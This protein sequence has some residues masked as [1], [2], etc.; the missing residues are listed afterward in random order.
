[1]R[2]LRSKWIMIAVLSCLIVSGMFSA[3]PAEASP[4]GDGVTFKGR[5]FGDPEKIATPITKAGISG[6]VVGEEDGKP[7]FYTS[8]NAEVA[9]F[10]IV[11]IRSNTLLR[12]FPMPGVQQA[13]AHAVAPDGTVYIGGIRTSGQ[14][15][16]ILWK[17]SPATKQI[18]ELGEPIPGEKSIWSLTVD[19]KGNVYGGTFQ[20]GRVFKYDPVA[21]T[22]T[23]YGT[24]VPGQEYVRSIAYHDGYIYAGIGTVGDVVKLGV[25]EATAGYKQSIGAEV[26]GLLGVSA[27]QVPFAYD[28][29][30]VGD[31]L[32]VKF[33][34]DLYKLLFYD[35]K[36]GAWLPHVVGKDTENG[37][38]GVG[39]FNFAQLAA[40]DNKV[41]IPANGHLTELDLTT[42]QATPLIRYGTSLRGA[43]WVSFDDLP[44]YPGQ[45]LVS[46][47]GN[48]EIAIFNVDA[49]TVYSMPSALIGAPNPIHNIEVG[50]DGSLYMSAYPAGLGA[51][52]DP[53]TAS[54]KNL[55][56]EQAEGMVAYG[57]DMYMGIY[58]G[59]HVYK[60]DTTQSTPVATRVF[61]IGE[62]QD[63]PY[64]M[65]T[66]GDK[67]MIGTIPGYGELG[68]ALTIFDPSTG[69]HKVY[70]N[71]VQNQ[72]IV[73]LAYKDGYIY[74]STT[75]HGGL[76]TSATERSA[77]LFVWDVANERKV[78]EFALDI[79]GIGQSP[80]IS[81]LTVGPD[82]N[83][84]GGV[85]G[86]LFKMDPV[87]HEILNYKN[88][89]PDITNYGMWRPYHPY[90]GK[91]GLLYI[92][93]ADR[94]TVIDPRTLEFVR[95]FPE[96]LEVKFMA[97]AEDAS[98][99]E[100][101]YF[102][103]ATDMG[104]LQRISVTDAQYER[105]GRLK[106]NGPD[107]VRLNETIEVALELEQAN[108]LYG[109]KAE[110]AIDP[111]VWTIE[112]VTAS[113]DWQS[114]GYMTWSADGGDVTIVGT[115]LGDNG[116]SLDGP[117]A[118]IRL[119][120]KSYRD[121]AR[122]ILLGES[123]TIRIDGD[124][125]GV[126]HRLGSDFVWPVTIQT[127]K[128][129]VNRDGVVTTDDLISLAGRIGAAIDDSN[130]HMDLN[131]DGEIDIADL[132]L[133]GSAV[134][135]LR[136]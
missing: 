75:I 53:R 63:R 103:D 86:I 73:G 97:L 109:F 34:G 66:M 44:G 123:E 12:S 133:V 47:K 118:K 14:T 110:L 22:F 13:W 6:A 129:D 114:N 70:R 48:G 121:K 101:I 108:A 135:E 2:K 42:F 4:G 21:G 45:S 98:G 82:G 3:A 7:V 52:Y 31:L 72:S 93:L 10:Q 57:T 59:G 88:I 65:K 100:Q 25:T 104:S 79:P 136:R 71:I 62:S 40:R 120:A 67:I 83:I 55:I 106:L 56:L 1:M 30:V 61:T 33:Q 117:L 18:V 77:K 5:V 122:L 51:V 54:L 125:T 134:F 128:E 90:W 69:E 102:A 95:L 46:M 38:T 112:S 50:P 124:V 119:T 16:G 87:T 115:R 19:D 74:G 39:V 81:G 37:G 113:D 27:A 28:M 99:Q 130:R 35:L 105:P 26:P 89:Y 8:V 23:D 17:Y 9:S 36:N 116:Y 41:Y 131:R 43:A 15:K 126:T 68:G 24:M 111:A 76:G 20:T 80:M 32:L 96:S 29:A 84:W 132:G 127:E 92:D 85:D 58:P 49:R 94:I 107:A 64:I 11:D 78:T 91:D 60:I